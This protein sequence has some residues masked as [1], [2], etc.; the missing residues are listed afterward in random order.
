MV[1]RGGEGCR[2]GSDC[3]MGTVS[4]LLDE[5]VLEMDGGRLAQHMNKRHRALHLKTIEMVNFRSCILY[6]NKEE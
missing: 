2:E 1:T 3:L 5:E 6:H 4:I